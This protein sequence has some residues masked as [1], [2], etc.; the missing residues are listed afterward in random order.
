[1]LIS[2]IQEKTGENCRILIR[3]FFTNTLKIVNDIELIRCHRIG[4][5]GTTRP[6]IV[7]FRLYEDK[8][9]VLGQR[10][11]LKDTGI[12]LNEDL[13]A[14]SKRQ[15]DSLIPVLKELKKVNP[16]AHIRGDKIFSDERLFTALNIYELPIDAHN[17]NTKSEKG[18]TLF[19]GR[20]SKLSN[21]HP[22]KLDIN[23]RIWSSVEQVYQYEKAVV[24]KQQDVASLIAATDDPLEVMHIGKTVKTESPEWI[25][26]GKQIMTIALEAKFNIP[27]FKLA[28]KKTENV[29]G[30]GTRH[31]IW[32]IGHTQ[33]YKDAF[34]KK[35][36]TGQNALGEMLMKIKM[37]L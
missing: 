36:W 7:R 6:L 8:E 11:L 16:R 31:P 12:F 18:V 4:K 30:E 37:S 26:R 21:L 32:G 20:F 1:M 14:E 33:G 3:H 5:P 34:D 25:E 13:C 2:G 29:I 23:G 10:R 35:T 28:L 19:S 15:R 27:A 17:A 22:C 9:H 24:A